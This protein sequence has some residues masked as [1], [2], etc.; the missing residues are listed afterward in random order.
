M[1]S[2]HN[3][4]LFDF[5]FGVVIGE[6]GDGDAVIGFMNQDYKQVAKEMRNYFPVEWGMREGSDHVMFEYDQEWICLTS[7]SNFD[8][9]QNWGPRI[10][11]W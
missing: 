7:K 5:V 6:G 3:K 9:C 1:G 11:T 2:E 8:N 4:L 10:L